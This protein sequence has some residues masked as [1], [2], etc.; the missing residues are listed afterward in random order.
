M[1]ICLYTETALPMVGGQ[2]MALDALARQ[3]LAAG[4]QVTLLAPRP[5]SRL[6]RPEPDVPYRVVRHARYLST[7]HFLGWYV[8]ALDQLWQRTPF[9]VLHCHNVFPAGEIAARFATRRRIPLVLTSHA[10]DIAVDS[11]LWK[12]PQ[13]LPRV[14][15][16]IE[17]ADA[18]VAISDMVEERFVALGADREQLV[19]IPNGVDGATLA[20]PVPRPENLCS[21]IQPDQY[22][23]FL[24]RLIPRKG[25]DLL[26]EAFL[27][28]AETSSLTLV[29]AGEG[30]QSDELRQRLSTEKHRDRVLLL[31]LVEGATKTYLLQHARSVV[32]PSRISEGSSLVVLE[33]YAAGRPVVATA[34]PGLVDVV[35]PERTGLLAV[36]DSTE[37]LAAAL[38][39]VASEPE[40]VAAWGTAAREWVAPYDWQQI[41]Q[42][43]LQL[44]S[45]LRRAAGRERRWELPDSLRRAA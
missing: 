16:V 14:R 12:K 36:E 44:Y 4:H 13:V 24:G 38:A 32:I 27:R 1:H 5:R 8:R 34:V 29:L 39:V 28:L 21:Q 25:A 31:G 19:R 9:D 35:L 40:R 6:R 10:C 2:E 3:Y 43:H 23:L 11:H 42:R 15:R 41:A 18:I 30:A 22:L 17:Q 26:V 7:R 20:T 45:E 33:A 37:S